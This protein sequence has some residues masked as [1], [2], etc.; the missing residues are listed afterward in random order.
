MAVI[1]VIAVIAVV[2]TV[3]TVATKATS[4]PWFPSP[5]VPPPIDEDT[6]A[7]IDGAAGC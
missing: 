2:A 6:I 3:A 1:D 7:G 5:A 4:A